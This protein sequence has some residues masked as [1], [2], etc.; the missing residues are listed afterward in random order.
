MEVPKVIVH[1]TPAAVPFPDHPVK[2]HNKP[3]ILLSP[4][5]QLTEKADPAGSPSID[6]P[7][8]EK[9]EAVALHREIDMEFFSSAAHVDFEQA[10]T[11]LESM[12]YS[13]F[14]LASVGLKDLAYVPSDQHQTA[15]RSYAWKNVH[16]IYN[17]LC[18][19]AHS[20]WM[21]LIIAGNVNITFADS[22]FDSDNSREDPWEELA[23]LPATPHFSPRSL[24]VPFQETQPG[25]QEEEGDADTS[26]GCPSKLEGEQAEETF[27]PTAT[28]LSGALVDYSSEAGTILQE[29]DEEEED[30][31]LTKGGCLHFTA[32]FEEEEEVEEADACSNNV[33]GMSGDKHECNTDQDDEDTSGLAPGRLSKQFK[34]RLNE[35]QERYRE[36]VLEAARGEGKDLQVCWQYLEEGTRQPRSINRWNAFKAWWASNG[37]VQEAPNESLSTWNKFLKSKYLEVLKLR[38][39]DDNLNDPEAHSRAMKPEVDWYR[40]YVDSY[41]VAAK[42]TGHV[43]TSVKR[44]MRPLVNLAKKINDTSGYHILSFV[45][46]TATDRFSRSLSAFV[47]GDEVARLA[48]EAFESKIVDQIRDLEAYVRLTEINNRNVSMELSTLVAKFLRNIVN[49]RL[50]EKKDWE[51]QLLRLIFEYDLKVC[52]SEDLPSSTKLNFNNFLAKAW[53]FKVRVV[54]WSSSKFPKHNIQRVGDLSTNDVRGLVIPCK[55][56]LEREYNNLTKRMDDEDLAPTHKGVPFKLERWS[57]DGHALAEEDMG[58]IALVVGI[59]N[60][61]LVSVSDV[62]SW[63]AAVG[64]SSATKKGRGTNSDSEDETAA[65]NEWLKKALARRPP[66]P[67]Q[68]HHPPAP[69]LPSQVE[70]LSRHPPLPPPHS[71][72]SIL[73]RHPPKESGLKRKRDEGTVDDE[74]GT[75]GLATRKKHDAR[76]K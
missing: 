60:Q 16:S 47:A 70:V 34:V 41:F 46:T 38:L 35:I 56:E 11:I 21:E 10:G 3:S 62:Q 50:E 39:S 40:D 45:I 74:K 7:P 48:K 31:S 57:D 33:G 32:E 65:Y 68:A 63:Q 42:D 53:M 76:G 64:G 24:P 27:S 14:S 23:A 17:K 44:I 5:N 29:E 51:K 2:P 6:A 58:D 13:L 61:T 66:P 15:A 36:S 18:L 71:H 69:S 37:D 8:Q 4:R 59:N 73:A 9:R 52:L 54:D 19:V 72:P 26:Q 28:A 22:A 75:D 25:T 55:F 30:V 1:K 20:E 12:N 67:P 49:G 43:R